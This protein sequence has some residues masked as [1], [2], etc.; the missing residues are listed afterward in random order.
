M[1]FSRKPARSD[2][3]ATE[4]PSRLPARARPLVQGISNRALA[5]LAARRPT[6][7]RF[8]AEEHTPRRLREE[9]PRIRLSGSVG[10]GGENF[11]EE[12]AEVRARLELLGYATGH[13]I[14]ALAN[15]TEEY[16]RQVL[17]FQ[18]PDGRVDP[19]GKTLAGLNAYRGKRGGKEPKPP[20]PKPPEPKPPEP[21]P[22]EPK[23]PEPK[24]Q[25]WVQGTWSDPGFKGEQEAMT[26]TFTKRQLYDE[27]GKVAPTLSHAF[28]TCLVGH[29]WSEQDATQGV[30]NY[31]FAGIEGSWSEAY[32]M[33]W[34]SDIIPTSKYENDPNKSNYRDWDFRNHNPKFG[35]IDGHYAGTIDYQLSLD[36]KPK[37]IA[38]A[39]KKRRPAFQSLAHGTAGF[40]K[41]LERRFNALRA[42]T[43]LKHNELAEKAFAG[44]VDSYAYIVNHKFKITDAS[45]KKRDF[46]AWNDQA[47][48][49]ELVRKQIAAAK[50]ELG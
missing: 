29:A 33:G 41:Q 46:G 49:F 19:G 23:P 28:K 47:V 25:G 20:E 43:D 44:D 14:D 50:K 12:V 32:V 9:T 11:E 36:P 39:V 15:A 22:P 6:L 8:L 13:S 21:K 40:L 42:S 37:R 27:I 34:T 4:P 17:G 24:S 48:Y 18:R 30:L 1:T 31:N 38:L 26:N 3:R 45:G 35:V 2:G 10:R 5:S 16:Q 7:A